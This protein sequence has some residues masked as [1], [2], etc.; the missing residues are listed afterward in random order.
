[1]GY[2]PTVVALREKHQELKKKTACDLVADAAV[3]SGYVASPSR[4][5][6]ANSLLTAYK[7]YLEDPEKDKRHGNMKLTE[8]EEDFFV[9]FLKGST[10][11]GDAIGKA[12]IFEAANVIFPDKSFGQSWYENFTATNN[13]VLKFGR[14]KS[15][16]TSRTSTATYDSTM[17]FT[18]H[19]QAHLK[20]TFPSS[21]FPSNF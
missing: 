7:R 6:F 16:S 20:S 21:L 13:D 8:D 5:T 1:M 19:L 10:C 15:T 12:E 3:E 2:V 18:E 9:G 17:Q 4:D 14:T 11:F